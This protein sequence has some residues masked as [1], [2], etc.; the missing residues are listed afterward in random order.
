[1]TASDAPKTAHHGRNVKRIREIL[2]IKQEVLA[3]QLGDDWNQQKVSILENKELI[4]ASILEQVAKALKVPTEAIKN[5]SEEAAI[6]IVAN[7]FHDF[8][9]N[10]IASAMNYQ[11]SFNPI[12]KIIQLYDE[13]IELFERMLREKNDLIERLSDKEE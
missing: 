7:T 8:K 9:D 4:E 13:K 12:D 2:G 6:H 11:C 10:A 1:M 5:F 3:D